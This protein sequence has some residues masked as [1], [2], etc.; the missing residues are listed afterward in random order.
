MHTCRKYYGYEV[1]SVEKRR[2]CGKEIEPN[3]T[4]R[5]QHVYV[6]LVSIIMFDR[7]S[8]VHIALPENT[9]TYSTVFGT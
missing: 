4:Y 6:E 8:Y 1:S 3:A 7:L 5:Y 2:K 9:T